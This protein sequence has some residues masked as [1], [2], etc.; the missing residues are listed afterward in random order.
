MVPHSVSQPRRLETHYLRVF[1]ADTPHAVDH[2]N[3]A[4]QPQNAE[5]IT[6]AH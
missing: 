4:F 2:A 5:H 3:G 6:G 1:L